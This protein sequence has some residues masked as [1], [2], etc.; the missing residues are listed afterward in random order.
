[1][2]FGEAAD[3]APADDIIGNDLLTEKKE[4]AILLGSPAV[5][6]VV[7]K[8]PQAE[9]GIFSFKASQATGYTITYLRLNGFIDQNKGNPDFGLGRD[10]DR[11]GSTYLSR[12][13]NN[14][15]LYNDQDE[16][17]A[18]PVNMSLDGFAVF[19]N[20]T[21]AVPSDQT[22]KIIVKADVNTE[23]LAQDTYRFSIDIVSDLDISVVDDNNI[24]IIPSG[25][26]PNNGLN[27]YSFLT[28]QRNGQ[29]TVENGPNNPPTDIVLSGQPDVLI[30]SLKFTAKYEPFLVQKLGFERIS[31]EANNTIKEISF[32]YPTQTGQITVSSPFSFNQVKFTNL[33]FYLPA[34]T[35]FTLEIKAET[36]PYQGYYN[37]GSEIKIKMLYDENF[38]VKGLESG[39]ELTYFDDTVGNLF[40]KTTPSNTLIVRQTKLSARLSP[41]T[42]ES[43]SSRGFNPVLRFEVTADPAGPAR[44]RKLTFKV[45]S[46][47]VNFI[48][49]DNDLFERWADVN[50]DLLDDDDVAAIYNLNDLN[51]SLAGGFNGRVEFAIFDHS[52]NTLD[53]TPQG[54]QTEANDYGIIKI[55]FASQPLISAGQTETFILYLNSAYIGDQGAT[56]KAELLGDNQNANFTNNNFEWHDGQMPATG[57]LI[58]NLPIGGKLL[59]FAEQ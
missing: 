30:Y 27:P 33:G 37:S 34:N 29:L 4:L 58:K 18:G 14:I 9:I 42:P 12:I 15:N 45:T 21:L 24:K 31:Q 44:L 41:E 7:Q 20:L 36:Y 50:G 3:I 22:I 28:I 59:T 13:L 35:D 43:L 8:K 47:S 52:A 11:D 16:L 26:S 17:I 46:S 54:F 48:G 55:S 2:A 56:L 19:N 10:D 40:N 1:M 57:Y 25:L 32:T 5:S 39:V 49:D 53:T 6:R 23:L 38:I 51:K